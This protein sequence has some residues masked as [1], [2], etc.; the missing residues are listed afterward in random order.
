VS[1]SVQYRDNAILAA[2]ALL[3]PSHPGFTGSEEIA[4][5]LRDSTLHSYIWSW[6]LPALR[7]AMGD[8]DHKWN[9][10]CCNMRAV[11]IRAAIRRELRIDELRE[12]RL[13]YIN[14]AKGNT[15]VAAEVWDFQTKE[16]AELIALLFERQQLNPNFKP[17]KRDA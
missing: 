8:L 11:S 16:G 5:R 7:T 3:D 1:G 12:M 13:N 9:R 10:D 14:G 6:V 4:A 2:L 15:N 17:S